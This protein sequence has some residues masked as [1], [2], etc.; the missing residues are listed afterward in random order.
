MKKVNLINKESTLN[1]DVTNALIDTI[2]EQSYSIM[3]TR[4]ATYY[5]I[6]KLNGYSAK[7]MYKEVKHRAK[8]AGIDVNGGVLSR[9]TRVADYAIINLNNLF[10]S[11]KL[12]KNKAESCIK[13]IAKIMADN[14][15]KY[16]ALQDKIVTKKPESADSIPQESNSQ[17]SKT[18]QKQTQGTTLESVIDF[19][20]NTTQENR[21]KLA[22]VLASAI[23]AN[24]GSRES[25]AEA[26]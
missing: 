5:F 19:I 13:E 12:D 8:L 26:M 2:L 18:T 3:F 25:I 6:M 11:V 21:L 10:T 24:A 4:Q 16:N 9:E 23:K 1:H 15:I 7:D 17:E 20:N 22:D 14:D